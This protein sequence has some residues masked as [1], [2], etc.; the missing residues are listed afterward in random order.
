MNAVKIEFGVPNEGWL[1]LTTSNRS[2][3][4]ILNISDVPCDPISELAEA[5][6]NLQF[7][8]KTEEVEFSLEPDFALWRFISFED[9]LQIHVFSNAIRDRPVIFKDNRKKLLNRIYQ[10]LK[11]LEKLP[12][13]Q[14]P[15]N[16][17]HVWSWDFSGEILNSYTIE[18]SE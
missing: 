14:H 4:I 7:G 13:W 1:E 9:E 5:V 18:E 3:C 10:A 8:S 15:D 12:C 17:M 16:M 11:D 6:I 2:Q